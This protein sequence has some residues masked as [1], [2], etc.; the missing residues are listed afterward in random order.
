MVGEYQIF[1]LYQRIM[2]TPDPEIKFEENKVCN[3]CRNYDILIR[4]H[5]FRAKEGEEEL[6]SIADESR[7][8]REE[9]GLQRWY[10]NLWRVTGHEHWTIV[11][12]CQV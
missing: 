9:M 10:H 12:L 11:E 6:K 4:T 5:V 1:T 2:D 8:L 7:R 3:H